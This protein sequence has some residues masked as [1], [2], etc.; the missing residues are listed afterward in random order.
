MRGHGRV[1]RGETGCAVE[2]DWRSE[3]GGEKSEWEMTAR[4]GPNVEAVVMGREGVGGGAGV[5]GAE[6]SFR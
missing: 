3:R 6:I 2:R 1:G 4:M 5:C